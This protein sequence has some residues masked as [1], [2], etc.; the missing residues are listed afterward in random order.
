MLFCFVFFRRA[1]ECPT[2]DV[3]Q[4]PCYINVNDKTLSIFKTKLVCFAFSKSV[5]YTYFPRFPGFQNICLFNPW[6][7]SRIFPWTIWGVGAVT[8]SALASPGQR[9]G[10]SIQHASQG[11]FVCIE[12]D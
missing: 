2:S 3:I 1:G 9:A 6:A 11:Y 10:C 7:T 5:S 12:D 8:P 4:G